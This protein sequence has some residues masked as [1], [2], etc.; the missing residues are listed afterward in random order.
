VR[1]ILN[2]DYLALAC[3]VDIVKRSAKVSVVVGTTLALINHG[4]RLFIGELGW[5]VVVKIGL[6]YFVPFGVAT[7]SAVMTELQS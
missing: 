3:R 5:V 7:W 1:L 4:E 6:T 2:S